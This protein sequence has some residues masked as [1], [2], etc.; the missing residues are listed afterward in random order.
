M[1]DLS[2]IIPS[3]NEQDT[4]E[5]T[6]RDLQKNMRG[7]TDVHV[8]LDRWL[9][10]PPIEMN[11]SRFHFHHFPDGI[12][13][14]GG[15]NYVCREK[16]TARYLFKL[17][18]HCAVSEGFD[19][20]L[21][22]TGDELGA[23]VTQVPLMYNLDV[24]TWIPKKHKRTVSMYLGIEAGDLRALYYRKNQPDTSDDI[25]ETMACMGPGWCVNREWFM[26]TGMCDERG[27]GQAGWGAQSVEVSCKAW[28]SG[29][30]LV[31]NK[32]CWFAH[33]FRGHVGFP[34][35]IGGREVS[36]VRKFH[37]DLWLNDA[38]EHRHPDRTFKWLIDK[39]NPPGWEDKVAEKED[40]FPMF[41]KMYNHIHRGKNL[42]RWRGVRVLKFGTDLLLY[43][44]VIQERQPDIII[45]IGTKHGGSALYF[46]DQ[47]AFYKTKPEDV[48]QP[49]VI[50]IDPKDFVLYDK[51][52]EDPHGNILFMRGKS[53]DETVL[54]RV[55]LLVEGKKVMV[56][57]DGDHSRRQV[58]WD[59]WNYG[60]FVTPGQYM[61]CED[62]YIDRGLYGPGE[63]RDW[64]LKGRKGWEL[65][66]LDDQFMG[67]GIT[68]GGWLLKKG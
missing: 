30:R 28:M 41:E 43:H 3:R 11:D 9:P 18:A 55:G 53:G 46:K 35:S 21:V 22:K 6:L 31:T 12:G 19:V 7:N 27:T 50:T 20:E 24:E 14:R 8:I 51:G 23:N 2:V 40:T 48:G 68:R 60:K 59:L 1:L 62:C 39:F 52:K 33:Y 37:T 58:K 56:V 67:V 10:S 32:R 34:Y 64:F 29:G 25:V 45:E 42:P 47:M 5:P 15:M 26:A 66:N 63:A 54:K 13:Q 17:D 65:T 4:L 44:Q 36:S 49:W 16:T 57:V 61:V 38:W